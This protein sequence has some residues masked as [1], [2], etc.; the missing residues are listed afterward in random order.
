MQ[1]GNNNTYCHDSELNWFNWEQAAQDNSGYARFFRHLINFRFNCSLICCWLAVLQL[2][3]SDPVFNLI[4][5]L[6]MLNV[7]Q[8]PSISDMHFAYMHG[9][10][11]T[12]FESGLLILTAGFHV[13][14]A[15]GACYHDL[16]VDMC[17][18][19]ISGR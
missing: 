15:G 18:A 5:T 1:G 16:W 6:P 10:K 9:V 19:E 11:M 7:L 13:V 8:I 12:N 17:L 3:M 14:S 4:T 2:R